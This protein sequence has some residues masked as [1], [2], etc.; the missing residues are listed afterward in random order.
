MNVT[1][2]VILS[3]ELPEEP[4]EEDGLSEPALEVSPPV[5]HA[6]NESTSTSANRT[7]NIFFIMIF[8]LHSFNKKMIAN[9]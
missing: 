6:A 4:S 9:I 2:T 5:E 8:F 1:P 7:A 3:P